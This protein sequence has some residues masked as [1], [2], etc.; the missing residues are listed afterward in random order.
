MEVARKSH[1]EKIYESKDEE[2]YSWFQ[3]YPHTSIEFIEY[4]QLPKN[5]RIID[6]GGGDSHLVDALLR[7]GYTDITVLDISAMAIEKA[8][9]RLGDRAD[10]VRWIVSDVTEFEPPAGQYDFWHDRAAFHFLTIEPLIRRYVDIAQRAVRPGG[11]LVLGTFSPSGPKKCSGLDI[12]QYSR[13]AM[14][15]VFSPFFRR[16]KCVE[17]MHVTPFQTTQHFLFCSFRRR[18]QS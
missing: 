6:I 3:P 13:A 2:A 17:A 8:R 1:W 16:V 7:L 4:F 10:R 12:R 15:A 5:A 14:S 9:K 18:R 11:Y